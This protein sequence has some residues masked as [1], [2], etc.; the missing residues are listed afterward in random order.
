MKSINESDPNRKEMGERERGRVK[1]ESRHSKSDDLNMNK[2]H[3]FGFQRSYVTAML[4]VRVEKFSLGRMMSEKYGSDCRYNVR[5][6]AQ[7]SF[8]STTRCMNSKRTK[9]KINGAE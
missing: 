3:F 7:T 1:Y 2:S 9:Q 6:F 5:A 4:H 8:V